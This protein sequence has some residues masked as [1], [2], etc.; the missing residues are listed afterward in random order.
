MKMKQKIIGIMSAIVVAATSLSANVFAGSV[1]YDVNGDGYVNARDA[2]VLLKMSLDGGYSSEYDFNED[3]YVNAKDVLY[4]LRYSL[5]LPSTQPVQTTVTSIKQSAAKDSILDDYEVK[6]AYNTLSD[7]LK[8]AYA[9]IYNG[10]KKGLSSIDVSNF[11][12]SINDIKKAFWACDYDNPQ[13]LNIAD[14]YAYSYFG[15]KVHSVAIMYGRDISQTKAILKEIEARTAD[16]IKKARTL[17]SDYKRLKL[18]HDW[19]VDNT[20]YVTT[21]GS[22]ISEIDGPVIHGEALCEGYSKTFAYLCQSIGIPCV[23][24]HGHGNG[25]DHMWNM[26]QLDGKWYHI[27]VTWD[28][29]ITTTGDQL[30]RYTYFLLSDAQISSNHIME[31]EFETPSAPNVYRANAYGANNTVF[32]P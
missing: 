22:H 20:T 6:W 28:D 23:C 16:V 25:G 27:D 4:L 17:T 30:R 15:S 32:C 26:V 11:D 24:V 9:A 7:N 14:G 13:L 3:G 1:T 2:L 19:I 8:K 31:N 5:D 21:G 29:P 10:A 12:V 18:F